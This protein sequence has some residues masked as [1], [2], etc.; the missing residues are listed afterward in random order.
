MVGPE[1]LEENSIGL[2]ELGAGLGAAPEMMQA[3]SDVVSADP[4][5]GVIF[6]ARLQQNGQLTPM[7]GDRFFVLPLVDEEACQVAE[8]KRD[9]R[10]ARAVEFLVD[11]K[12]LPVELLGSIRFAHVT[13]IVG[14]VVREAAAEC[15]APAES[16]ARDTKRPLLP[17]GSLPRAMESVEVEAERIEGLRHA[18]MVGSERLKQTN[19]IWVGNPRTLHRPTA[20][21][22]AE[23]RRVTYLWGSLR[24]RATYRISERM[25]DYRRIVRLSGVYDATLMLLFA[26]PG[27]VATTMD[28]IARVHVALGLQ[29]TVPP[30]PLF[31]HFFI[32]MMAIITMVWAVARII[33]P[34]PNYG[35]YDGLLR[36][37]LAL[38]MVGYVTI[39]L[40]PI[41]L[42]F[43]V[44]E[45]AWATLQL[46][47][48]RSVRNRLRPASPGRPQARH[49]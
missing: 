40:T 20:K 11:T 3:I 45:I 49:V 28:S 19:R 8:R 31:G 34:A 12:R 17:L 6:A 41:L 1:P 21:R 18:P 15:V 2:F 39:G 46:R 23:R 5:G 10:M 16:L 27:L 14:E 7:K 29:G 30:L 32:N 43:A 26:F 38:L 13:E 35:L 9:A 47:G 4:D 25:S 44:V 42:L 22:G 37:L 33:D 24:G 36:V 48:Y